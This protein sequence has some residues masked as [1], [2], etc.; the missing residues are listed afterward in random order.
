MRITTQTQT[1]LASSR[2]EGVTFCQT[3]YTLLIHLS[4]KSAP[5]KLV[6]WTRTIDFCSNVLLRLQRMLASHSLISWVPTRASLQPASSQS[7]T[8]QWRK[9]C[10]LRQSTWPLGL[11]QLCLQ[12][13]YL[14]LLV[15]LVRVSPWTLP[16]LPA[17]THSTS[18]VKTFSLENVL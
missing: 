4:S 18:P 5:M 10:Q 3:I 8:S 9:I 16:A 1:N 2:R 12:T 7:T 11:P 13:V 17:R 6:P 14:T 15:L